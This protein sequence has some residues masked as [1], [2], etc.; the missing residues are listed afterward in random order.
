[1]NKD[2]YLELLKTL[3]HVKNILSK[4][5]SHIKFH[6]KNAFYTCKPNLGNPTLKIFYYPNLDNLNIKRF[7]YKKVVI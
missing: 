3:M 6:R 2:L 1:M 4:F 5:K 7:Y